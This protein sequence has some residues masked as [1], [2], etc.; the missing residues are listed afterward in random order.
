[1]RVWA[2]ALT[3]MGL[4]LAA[5]APAQETTPTPAPMEAPA[6]RDVRLLDEVPNYA[7]ILK[8]QW[9]AGLPEDVTQAEQ[10]SEY[11]GRLVDLGTTQGL[12]LNDC[13]ALA[14][15]NNTNLQ[16]QRLN[17]V[18][19]TTGVR[20]AWSQFDPR[21]TGYVNRRRNVVPA[22][23]FLTAGAS[24]SLFTSELDANAGL[25]KMLLSGGALALDFTNQRLTTNPSIASPVVPQYVST[26]GLSL[27]QPLLRDFGWRYALLV[28][29]IA[30]NTEQ[31]AY[32][33][34]EASIANTI[35]Q[36]EAAYWRYVLAIEAVQVQEQSLAL[37]QELQRQNEG[38]YNV[39]ALPQTA[40]L[41]AK[42]QVASR[43][44][45]LIQARNL[46]VI[47][48]DNL[49]ALIN[50][51]DQGA[52]A[53]MMIKPIDRPT[54]SDYPIDL[55]RSLRTA[56][57]QRPELIAAR[58][59]VHGAGLQRKVA[60][61]QLLPRLNFGG[62]VGVNGLAGTDARVPNSFAPTPGTIPV[63]PAITGGY[64]HALGLLPDG[65][66]YSWSAGATL[67]VPIDNAQAK[68]DYSRANIDFEQS[69]LSLR[70]LQETVTLEIKQAVSNLET[71]LKSIDATRIARSLAEE[72]LRNQKARYD[73]GLATTKDL[74]DYQDQLTQARFREID[75]LTRYNTDLAEMRRV[76]GSLLSARN[77]LIER[78]TPEEQP[79]WASF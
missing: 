5:G 44:A 28:V 2:W 62:G 42:S 20:R 6:P 46:A 10:S 21:A 73:V 54:V 65:R 31:A 36:V 30:Q 51:R 39:G 13:V 52:L 15:K 78:M 33:Q 75:A 49:R 17:P 14:L 8:D 38:K 76:E 69:S 45:T 12:T 24:P 53:L 41:E 25:R 32:Y 26:L 64:G 58:L 67:E 7:V 1:M 48:R 27:N 9:R 66:F 70:Q 3:V 57:E 60:E 47:A 18:A 34:Y 63:N 68:A 23:T 79:W 74:L 77:V 16:I 29:E 72:N 19:A 22:T 4:A 40:V 37:A 55:E 50:A 71:D 56:F 59:N 35:A 61:N 11:Y 43:E